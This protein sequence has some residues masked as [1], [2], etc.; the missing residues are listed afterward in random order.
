MFNFNKLWKNFKKLFTIVKFYVIIIISFKV[1]VINVFELSTDYKLTGDR[2][3]VIKDLTES[4]KRG[5]K[6][7]TLLGVTGL[8]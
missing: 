7:N 2:P 5:N 3:K 4:I 1:E 6:Q 8:G